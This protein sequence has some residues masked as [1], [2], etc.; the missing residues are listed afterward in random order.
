MSPLYP[1]SP[2]ALE[3]IEV[4]HSWLA[5]LTDVTLV[6]DD[7]YWRLDWC[8]LAI[9]DTDEDDGYDEDDEDM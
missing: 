3:V 7:T 5:D 8:S 2:D 9:E 6:S 4:S 1:A